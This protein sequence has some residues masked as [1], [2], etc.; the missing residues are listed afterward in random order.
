MQHILRV[1]RLL[2]GIIAAA[3]WSAV[4]VAED[5]AD[6][7][8][9]EIRPLLETFCLRCH[10]PKENK[11]GLNLTRFSSI[12]QIRSDIEI[13]QKVLVRVEREE[14][15]PVDQPQFGP[16]QRRQ[17]VTWLTTLIESEAARRATDPGPVLDRRLNNAEYNYVIQDLTGVDLQ[18]SR[19]FPADG[20]AG[21]G[22]LNATE[23]LAIPPELMTRYLG[24]AK[25][26][27]AHAVLIPG[28][29]R[30]SESKFRADWSNQVLGRITDIYNIY[31]NEF[32]QIPFSRYL[33]ATVTHRDALDAAETT[34]ESTAAREGL[35]AK[36]LQTLWTALN[37]AEQTSLFLDPVRS[38][39]R[40]CRSRQDVE[41]LAL[42]VSML[43]ALLWH[44]RDP[45]GMHSLDDRY[46]PPG[47]S[48]ATRHTY[49]LAMPPAQ[50]GTITF[51]LSARTFASSDG[52]VI[53][54]NGRFEVDGKLPVTLRE[55]LEKTGKED[56]ETDLPLLDV[57]RL[58]RHPEGKPLDH[59]SLVLQGSETAAIRSEA[60]LINGRTFVVDVAIESQRDANPVVHFD[61]RQTANPPAVKRGVAW[62]DVAG[63]FERFFLTSDVDAMR[64]KLLAAAE[65]FRQLFPARVCY[66]GVLVRDTVVTLERFHRGDGFLSRLLLT[67]Q[68][69]EQLN[70]LWSELH[71]IS[72]DALDVRES[73][74]TVVQ[75]ELAGYA[76]VSK[77]IHRRAQETEVALRKSEP[78]QIDALL[79]FAG[80][81]WRRSLQENE[82]NSLR[83]FYDRLRESELSHEDAFRAALTRVLMS[84]AYL[85]RLESSPPGTEPV[86]VTNH[87][88]A[89]R[90]SFFLWASMPDAALRQLADDGSLRDGNVL[91]Q[92]VRRMLQDPRGRRLAIEFGTQWLEVRSFNQFQGK[93]EELFPAFKAPLRDAM[94]EES[95]R[96][97]QDLFKNDRT[98]RQLVD[99]DHTFV[100][101]V[102]AN[103]YGLPGVEGSDFRRVDGV[104][105][106]G[107]GGILGLGSILSK[108]S[109][110]SRTSP[111]LRGNWIA[112]ILLGEHLPLPP[113][114]VPKLP[115]AES[116]DGLSI[117]QL[118]EQHVR[119]PQCAT[120]HKR[121]D[122]LGFALEEFDTIGRRREQDA[123]GRPIDATARL[124]EGTTFQGIDGLRRYLLTER[125]DE[126][127]RQ[128]C[129]KLL[130]Y[131]L[132]R[133]VLLSDRQLLNKMASQLEKNE[134]RVLAAVLAIVRSR[135]FQFIRGSEFADY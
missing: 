107:R 17:V 82:R 13:W 37:D 88:L 68:E 63:R 70:R 45:I 127:Q 6:E 3:C 50:D 7:Y 71:F 51:F 48:L 96:L 49:R 126:F 131:A 110:A 99:A 124:K 47:I 113:D 118:V 14:M 133:R 32:G 122:P 81:A 61:T 90:L 12:Q 106:K 105:E 23:A 119:M 72:L 43:Q 100:N 78:R 134:G 2:V 54:K 46:V 123:G 16:R 115:E 83:Q 41:A 111:V 9:S 132:G 74:K 121:I 60:S 75:G 38:T 40:A 125:R 92:Q 30:F 18:P 67:D 57:S 84:P 26:V 79:D 85:Y 8:A 5:R 31:T 65:E 80:R 56:G 35:S 93:D 19:Q 39:W 102:L 42:E 28:G 27:A 114:D 97:F 103:H 24:A 62:T 21:E 76:E 4:A 91:E 58:G 101:D 135:Q 109:S 73:F 104:Q 108:H 116:I 55:V 25:N 112:E 36:Y 86:A 1:T 87:E 129:R 130:G 59:A 34:I 95:I 11:G 22:F 94:Y 98:I 120:C 33:A 10:S 20:A 128:F 69:Q 77:V 29:F 44:K 66:P 89:T 53:L 117:R 15:P 52:L 64:P